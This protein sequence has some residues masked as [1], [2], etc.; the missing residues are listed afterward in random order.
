MQCYALTPDKRRC[1]NETPGASHYCAAHES[2]NTHAPQSQRGANG[3]SMFLARVRG[4]LDATNADGGKYVVPN[5]L[6]DAPTPQ[7]IEHLRTDPDSM[8]RWMAAYVLRKRRA[9]ETIESLWYSL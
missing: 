8:V 4:A 2:S 5:W 7:V 3:F 1:L 9:Q 6:Q